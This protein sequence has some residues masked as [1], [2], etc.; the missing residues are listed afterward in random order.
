MFVMTHDNYDKSVLK[1]LTRIANALDRINKH[2]DNSTVIVNDNTQIC[3]AS[4]YAKEHPEFV[5]K[6]N[7]ITAG[8]KEEMVNLYGQ[9]VPR[10]G[11]VSGSNYDNATFNGEI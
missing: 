6:M 8:E 11:I 9:L 4:D 10:K 2:L 7:K 1:Q 3:S 5:E